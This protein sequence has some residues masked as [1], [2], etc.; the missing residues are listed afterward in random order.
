MNSKNKLITIL[1]TRTDRRGNN[2]YPLYGVIIGIIFFYTIA[3][4]IIE[5]ESNI[6]LFGPI[7]FLLLN[8]VL[9]TI[10]TIITHKGILWERV[11]YLWWNDVGRI[12]EQLKIHLIISAIGPFGTII[13]IATIIKSIFSK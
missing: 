9:S 5:E 7:I 4:V 8:L 13:Y 6:G 10:C 3:F 1:V 11:R 2:T 12:S